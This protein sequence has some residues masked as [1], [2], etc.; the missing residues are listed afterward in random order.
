MKNIF[1]KTLFALLF[2][3]LFAA[4]KKDDS[5]SVSFPNNGAFVRDWGQSVSVI[6]ETSNVV[7]VTVS[8]TNGWEGSA[9][10]AA[11]TLTVTAP[12]NEEVE[13]ADK[14][15][16]VTITA[17]S[18]GG[19]TSTAT[20]YAYIVPETVDLS[21]DGTSNCYIITAPDLK[22]R[23]KADVKGES[24]ERL[25]TASV[26]IVWTT[27]NSLVRYLTLTDDGYAE[28]Y[29]DYSSDSDT[30]LREGNVL[31]AAYNTAEEIIWSWHLWLT[32]SDP[33]NVEETESLSNG[34]TFMGRNLGAMKNSDGSTD[35]DDILASYGL[36]YQWGR[37]DPFP[38]PRYYNCA[39]NLDQAI[40]NSNGNYIY[41]SIEETDAEKGTVAYTT[42]NP[43]IYLTSPD[44]NDG[45]WL[46]GRRDDS[47]WG[48]HNGNGSKSMYDPCPHGWQVPA[49]NDFA[50]FELADEDDATELELAKQTFGWFLTDKMSGTRHFYTGAGYRS[51]FDGVLSNINYK[52]QYPYTPVPWVGYYW[53]Q[54]VDG[55]N[56]AAMFFDL[57]TSRATINAF[58][59]KI[60]QHRAN[61]MQVRCVKSERAAAAK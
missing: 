18:P 27:A 28:F 23:F 48:N 47:L 44:G 3:L 21:A 2:A 53:T 56:G 7:S 11:H 6:F 38:R 33:R 40:Y 15:S 41:I 10:L 35:H 58:E 26:D 32:N 50:N 45:D 61:G 34:V 19:A 25:S 16:S 31:I 55:T 9:N 29:I 5:C 4:C 37:K 43:A 30:E 54:G 12:E 14:T 20:L 57:N 52:D 51:Y 1:S 24:G 36:Y 60:S 49:Q 42:A 46:Y 17:T 39:H 59:P 13:N 22:Y 8:A